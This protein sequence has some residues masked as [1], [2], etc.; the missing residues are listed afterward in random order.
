MPRVPETRRSHSP[1]GPAFGLQRT[2][3][4]GFFMHVLVLSVFSAWLGLVSPAD[5]VLAG[6]LQAMYDEISQAQL[7]A[8]TADDVDN[9]HAVSCTPDWSVAGI[10]GVHHSWVDVRA[11]AVRAAETQPF[12]FARDIILRITEQGNEAVTEVHSITVRDMVDTAGKYGAAG[13]HHAIAE[14]TPM[15]DHWIRMDTGWKQQAREQM[16]AVK[17][18]LDRMP[19]EVDNPK[20]PAVRIS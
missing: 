14:V 5:T 8:Q 7:S 18:Y 19:P 2:L 17:E 11:E 9:F 10:D 4:G 15:R 13:A 3:A 16:G 1:D 20:A 6:D 12:S